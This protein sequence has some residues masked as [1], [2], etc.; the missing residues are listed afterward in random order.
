[1]DACRFFLRA[2]H[3]PR[4]TFRKNGAPLPFTHSYAAAFPPCARVMPAARTHAHANARRAFCRSASP[5]CA[6]ELTR[7]T[8]LSHYSSVLHNFQS[9]AFAGPFLPPSTRRRAAPR[10]LSLN[11]KIKHPVRDI[12]GF[13]MTFADVYRAGRKS[14]RVTQR[15][16]TLAVAGLQA[17]RNRLFP[18]RRRLLPITFLDALRLSRGTQHTTPSLLLLGRRCGKQ[19]A[20]YA[21]FRD[22][23]RRAV[24]RLPRLPAPP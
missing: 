7:G 23:L 5:T 16:R 22:T 13:R 12:M 6:R 11:I 4:A 8:C 19:L 2:S 15:R 1:M 9:V 20:V 24:L 10:A 21:H 3:V 18:P 17:P 14:L